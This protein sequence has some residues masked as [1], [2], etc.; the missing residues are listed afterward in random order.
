[1]ATRT[2]SNFSANFDDTIFGEWLNRNMDQDIFQ[3]GMDLN[4]PVA[5][6]TST[7]G[8]AAVSPTST[9]AGTLHW[10]QPDSSAYNTQKVAYKT[11]QSNSSVN[12]AGGSQ[13]DWSVALDGWSLAV[14]SDTVSSSEQMISA[15]DP[16]YTDIYFPTQQAQLISMLYPL[17]QSCIVS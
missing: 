1:M 4:P 5:T 17:W 16:Y 2:T 6:P 14:G 11:V 15:I 10:L 8:Q 7:T 3:F 13:P 12:Y 9:N